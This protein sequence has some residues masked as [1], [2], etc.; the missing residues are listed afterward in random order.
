MI[1]EEISFR[2][3]NRIS[4]ETFFPVDHFDTQRYELNRTSFLQEIFQNTFS[5]SRHT[6]DKKL[7]PTFQKKVYT[8][9]SISTG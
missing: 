5:V 2:V 3:H 1:S 8:F 6:K 4:T 7:Y 9:C